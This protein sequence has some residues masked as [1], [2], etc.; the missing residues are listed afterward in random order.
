MEIITFVWVGVT[1]VP[2]LI[3]LFVRDVFSFGV[4][5]IKTIA[6]SMGILGTF[7]GIA[8]SL[9]HFDVQ[10]ITNSVPNLLEGLKTAFYT[11]IAGLF[12]SLL[13]SFKEKYALDE[14]TENVYIENNSKDILEEIKT[15]NKNFENSNSLL[16]KETVEF[17]KENSENL[18]KLNASFDD[19]SKKM[20]DSNI[21]ALTE[22]IE[23]VMGEFNTTI[24]EK[25]GVT[26]DNFRNS[27][28]NLNNWQQQYKEQISTH[29]EQIT[30]T[31]N[32]VEGMEDSISSMKESYENINKLSYDF[33]EL[34]K[35]LN[36][37]LS[38]SYTFSERMSELSSDLEGSGDMIKNEVKEIVN[39]TVNELEEVMRKTLT[40]YG[41]NLSVI[42]GKMTEDFKKV[43][44]ALAIK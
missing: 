38:G 32:A 1:L 19:F 6:T 20:T 41:E 25:L 17:K 9:Y 7:V 34:M 12:I 4:L 3:F 8:Y 43:Q 11:S 24:N 29:L 5:K 26:F 30:Q 35:K 23:K 42:S 15:L 10:D 28:E 22:A 2:G 44:E 21:D 37:Q 33:E 13:A 14:D 27:V 18:S 39:G 36:E 16:I 40:D 31:K